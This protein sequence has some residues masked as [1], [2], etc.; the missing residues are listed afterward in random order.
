MYSIEKVDFGV[1]LTFAGFIREDEM[2]QWY[3][4][5]QQF[6]STL[7]PGFGI[8]VD[9]RGLKPLPA[10]SQDT[11]NRGQMMYMQGGMTRAAVVLDNATTTMQFIR[12]G[13]EV[14]ILH[15]VKYINGAE[16][17]W[18]TKAMDWILKGEWQE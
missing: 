17:D 9:M 13:K 16:N 1:K 8:F 11:M 18:E 5:S 10:E 15:M 12:L 6:I 14:G 3:K 2:N 7:E 4:E